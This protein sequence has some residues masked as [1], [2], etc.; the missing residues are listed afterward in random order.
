MEPK[1]D[2]FASAFAP[3]P[4]HRMV[5][6]TARSGPERAR[7]VRGVCAERTLDGE[8]RSETWG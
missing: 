8:D 5:F 2:G 3:F 4:S 1:A 7:S 6:G